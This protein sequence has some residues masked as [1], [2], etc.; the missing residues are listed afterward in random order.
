MKKVLVLAVHP[1]DETLGCAGALLKHKAQ[2]DKIY[3]VIATKMDSK[4]GYSRG[5]IAQVSKQIRKVSSIYGFD[6]VVNLGFSTKLT[7]V[8]AFNT[9]VEKISAV[10]N[11][12]KPD[13]IYLPF[14]ADAHSDHRIIFDAA[15]SCT[16]V[17]RYPF[18]KMILMM[19]TISETEFGPA[20]VADSFSPNYFVDI[21]GFL[22]KK[23]DI[24]K[25][26]ERELGMHPF[27][28][29][30]ENIKALAVFRGAMA[31]CRFAESFMLL[32]QIC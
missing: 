30:A 4:S 8:V 9:L 27:P 28:R 25:I 17:F 16:K 19:E 15:Y 22:D 14:K 10:F 12:I 31:G 21:S 3:W 13:T 26:Y 5:H 2:G 1:D 32:K 6:K 7:D 23:I 11:E 24:M 20:G 29:S 18:I